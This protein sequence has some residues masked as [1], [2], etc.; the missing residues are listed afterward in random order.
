MPLQTPIH[1]I[2]SY[3]I[4]QPIQSYAP[5]FAEL[6]QSEQWWHYLPSTWLV[7]RR[8]TLAELQGKCI[9]LIYKTDLLLILPAKGP[10]GGWLPQEASEWIN[11]RLPR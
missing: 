5:L 10:A 3:D 1:Y 6:K 4:K 9:P 7:L 2:I 8:D 11:K